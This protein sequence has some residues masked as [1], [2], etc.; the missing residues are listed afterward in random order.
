MNWPPFLDFI[1]INFISMTFH[2]KNKNRHNIFTN[3]F[4]I[5]FRCQ[6]L[7]KKMIL[8]VDSNKNH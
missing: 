8:V 5:K 6:V 4:T 2:K 7:S 3:N 1:S